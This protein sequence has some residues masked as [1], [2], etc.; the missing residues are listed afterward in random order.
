MAEDPYLYPETNTLRNR[1]GLSDPAQLARVEATI[2]AGRLAELEQRPIA[3]NYDLPH[4]Q[5]FHRH[6]FGDVFDWAGEIRTVAIARHDLFALPEHIESYLGGVLAQL[7]AEQHLRGL[8]REAFVDRLT[9]YL[10]EINASHPFREGNGRTQRA[11]IGQL[12][13]DAGYRIDWHRLDPQL[14][15]DASRAAHRGDNQPLRA[16]LDGLIVTPEQ[17][18]IK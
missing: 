16:M 12:A 2:T 14:N 10:A 7:P 13:Q 11:F 8:D 17:D 3:G 5:A 4:L 18:D 9:Y 1:F 6:I 15:I